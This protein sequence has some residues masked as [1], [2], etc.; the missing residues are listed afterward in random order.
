MPI[1][2]ERSER[3]NQVVVY[4]PGQFGASILDVC[5]HF[6]VITDE[7]MEANM[8]LSFSWMMVE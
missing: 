5:L 7:K 1:K 3:L 6:M 2:Y 4:I 8:P